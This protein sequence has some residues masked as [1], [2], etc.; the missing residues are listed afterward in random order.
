MDKKKFPKE[1]HRDEG[2]ICI[3]GIGCSGSYLLNKLSLKYRVR[4][5]EAGIDRRYDG[6][7]FNLSLT[8]PLVHNPTD[9][10]A[11][12]N[13]AYPP[14]SMGGNTQWTGLVNQLPYSV[15]TTSAP[16]DPPLIGPLTF[17][18]GVML[19]GSNEHIQGVYVNPSEFRCD[20]WASLLCDERWAF[21]NLFP[22]LEVTEEFRWHTAP[23]VQTYDG[24]TFAPF[25]GPSIGGSPPVNRGY[26][27]VIQAVQYPASQ[28][29]YRLA[30]AIYYHFHDKLR[31]ESFRIEPVISDLP[32]APS[33]DGRSI[34]AVDPDKSGISTSFNSGVNACVTVSPE[35]WLDRHRSRSSVARGYLKPSVQMISRTLPV[36][37]IY[38]GVDILGP[39]DG[40]N[41]YDFRLHLGVL[42]QRIVFKTK[43]GYPH[44]RDYWLRNPHVHKVEPDAFVWPLRAIGVVYGSDPTDTIFVPLEKVICSSGTLAT[45]VLLMQ[46]G[47][48]PAAL[49]KSLQIPVL[50][51]QPNVGKYFSNQTGVTMTWTGNAAVW[52]VQ[53]VGTVNSN[54]YL[55][56]KGQQGFL[57][58]PESRKFQYFSSVTATGWSMSFYDLNSHSTGTVSAIKLGDTNNGLLKVAIDPNY[59]S[60]PTGID[61]ANLCYIVRE[62]AA[63]IIAKDPTA[64]FSFAGTVVPYPFPAADSVLFP[65][66]IKAF[67]QQAH[68]VGGCGMSPDPQIS[69]VDTNFKVRGT[70]NVYVC[71]ASS[72][73]LARDK[74]GNVFPVANDGNTSRGVMSFS[75][76]FA[77]Q[78]LCGPQ[79]DSED[80]C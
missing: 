51:D 20:E 76:I 53:E 9:M 54:G 8:A 42:I 41:G 28:F 49:L 64:I 11:P 50:L 33:S 16:A 78:L 15:T 6:F 29:S 17:V 67:T 66:I 58:G 22:K 27:G 38:S 1:I 75:I 12:F 23:T 60:D 13:P 7:S 39:Y 55:P 71:D 10:V 46:S 79:E 74:V 56:I 77:D 43:K 14:P 72:F 30:D 2:E 63:A 59:Y 40:I 35:T 31:V 52:G 4:A 47:I 62:A 61:I 24:S 32:P 69:V 57:E 19:G 73:P 21:K 65:I 3:I 70:S 48:G 45:P 36:K 5:F 26:S 18:Q 68:Y 34:T 37:S 44:A 80:T 25:D